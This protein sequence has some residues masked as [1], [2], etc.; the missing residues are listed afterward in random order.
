MQWLCGSRNRFGLYLDRNPTECNRRGN[1][2]RKKQHSSPKIS[3]HGITQRAKR[4]IKNYQGKNIN[5]TEGEED[6]KF[7][8]PQRS[9]NIHSV[10]HLAIPRLENPEGTMR[11]SRREKGWTP[12]TAWAAAR[13]EGRWG[14]TTASTCARKQDGEKTLWGITASYWARAVAKRQG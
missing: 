12:S 2:S 11:T 6:S 3:P 5:R 9:T 13:Q 10:T 4:K 8:P 1:K 7:R 14:S